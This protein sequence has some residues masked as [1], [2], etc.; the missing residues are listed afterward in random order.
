MVNT[1]NSNELAATIGVENHGGIK[2][3]INQEAS[4]QKIEYFKELEVN[5]PNEYLYSDYMDDL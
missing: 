5:Y 2:M 1:Y 3:M 4:L